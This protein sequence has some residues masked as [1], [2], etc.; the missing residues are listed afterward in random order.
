[1]EVLSFHLHFKVP[2]YKHAFKMSG[3]SA[4][5]AL[6]TAAIVNTKKKKKRN[7]GDKDDETL[8]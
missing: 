1:M 8:N 2:M 6:I 5:E 7:K 3:A 4:L